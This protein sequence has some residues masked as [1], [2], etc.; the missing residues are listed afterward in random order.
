[1]K[2]NHFMADSLCIL[3]SG[4]NTGPNHHIA[5]VS[6]QLECRKKAGPKIV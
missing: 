1:M 3:L 6:G 5:F 2:K 4:A